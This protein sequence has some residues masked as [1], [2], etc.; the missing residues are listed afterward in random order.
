MKETITIKNI[1]P[2]KNVESLS[3][4]PFTVLIGESAS[5]K[6]TLMKLVSMMRYLYKMANI[7]SYLKHSKITNSPFRMRFDSM[8]KE[9]GM[10]K[11]LDSSSVIRYSVIMDDGTEY[12]ILMKDK[13]LGKLPIISSSHLL[14]NK[15]SYISENRNIIPTWTQKASQNAGATLGFYFHETNNDFIRA[16][17]NDK[18]IALNYIDMKLLITHPKGKPTRYTIVPND[19][20]HEPIELRE[21]SSGIQTSASIALIVKDYASANGFSFKDAFKRSVLN[22]LYDMERL[23]K[24]KAVTEP[25]NLKKK[26]YIHVEEPELSLFPD[27][28]CRLIEEIVLSAT[29]AEEDREVNIILA[30]HSPYIL[31]YLNVVLNQTD[32]ERA[33]LRKDNTAVYRIF[34]GEVQDLLVQNERGRWIVDTYDLSEMMS[35]IY[36]EFV[37]LDV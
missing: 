9:T 23:N 37:N 20:R 1:G 11:M 17:E 15:V 13:K 8:M 3:I 5:G 18:E 30:T 24:F 14:F 6:S 16:S 36:N 33:Q 21:A 28:Q 12:T 27:T 26:V 7:R 32:A 22:Y 31:N 4:L 29:H 35:N 25:S 19:S 34:E 10:Y 2:L